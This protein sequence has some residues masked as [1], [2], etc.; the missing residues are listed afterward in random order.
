[1]VLSCLRSLNKRH[2]AHIQEVRAEIKYMCTIDLSPA[3]VNCSSDNHHSKQVHNT[4]PHL[5]FET[6]HFAVSKKP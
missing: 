5:R 3:E 2:C 6:L 4:R 1:M